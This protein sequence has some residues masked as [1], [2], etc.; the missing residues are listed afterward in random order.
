MEWLMAQLLFQ[1]SQLFQLFVASATV[2]DALI[3]SWRPTVLPSVLLAGNPSIGKS[4]PILRPTPYTLWKQL[5]LRTCFFCIHFTI[6]LLQQQWTELIDQFPRSLEKAS[7]SRWPGQSKNPP[8]MQKTQVQSLGPEDPL[9]KGMV[10]CPLQYPCLENP[11]DIGAWGASCGP[12]GHK[13]WD[14]VEWL[15]THTQYFLVS[16]AEKWVN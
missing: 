5:F 4:Y 10:G 12:W 15:S 13:E 9:K 3:G 14:M 6:H 1:D 11:T 7:Y 16:T 2:S 8:A